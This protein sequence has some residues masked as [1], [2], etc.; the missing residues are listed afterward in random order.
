[1]FSKTDYP[2]KLLSIIT[3]NYNNA[4]GLEKTIKSVIPQL[5]SDY[6][7]IV[8]DGGS[9]DGS[10]AVIKEFGQKISYWV[11]EPDKGIYNAMNKGL[12]AAEGDYILFLNSGDWLVSDL[13]KIRQDISGKD[14]IYTN[15]CFVNDNKITRRKYDFDLSFQFFSK[16][17]IPHTGNAFIKNELF[18]KYGGY[19]E[20]LRVVSDWKFY[21]VTI[22]LNNCSTQYIDLDLSYVDASGISSDSSLRL[23]ERNIVLNEL[24]PF[25]V[26]DY[27]RLEQFNNSRV[28]NFYLNNRNRVPIRMLNYFFSIPGKI[29][30]KFK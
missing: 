27:E 30:R 28:C 5:S 2:M 13:N 1:M 8:I 16:T 18:K 6:E 4:K 24:F 20:T 19:D 21:L 10:V 3:I 12:A 15:L 22:I 26:K 7:Y 29:L 9:T 23:K 17:S 25:F 11:S 14:I